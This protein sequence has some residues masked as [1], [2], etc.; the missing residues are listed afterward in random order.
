MFEKVANASTLKEAWE[1]LG[2]SLRGID[3]VKKIRLQTL[4]GEFEK[5]HMEEAES[6]SNY[7]SRVL[8][9]VNE[10]KSNVENL[11]DTT[12]LEKKIICSLTKSPESRVVAIVESKD[13]ESMTIDQLMGSLQAHEER[14]NKKKT[15]D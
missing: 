11:D 8:T 13:I 5:L 10:M 3:K 9:L 6:I 4:S 14:L 15:Q 2:N 12:V 7:F 1:I